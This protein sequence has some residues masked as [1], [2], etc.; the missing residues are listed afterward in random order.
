[1]YTILK[2]T[3]FTVVTRYIPT[4]VTLD[5]AVLIVSLALQELS[6]AILLATL[7]AH[8]HLVSSTRGI[9][10][11]GVSIREHLHELPSPLLNSVESALFSPDAGVLFDSAGCRRLCRATEQLKL[12]RDR[13][14]LSPGLKL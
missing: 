6:S 8:Q 1:M 12:M 11:Q 4:V 3:I 14:K 2:E 10:L 7:G 5:S 9:G 13:A